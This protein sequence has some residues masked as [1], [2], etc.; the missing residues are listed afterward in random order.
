MRGVGQPVGEVPHPR[1]PLDRHEDGLH[2]AVEDVGALGLQGTPVE[3]GLE[4]DARQH[5][6]PL[7]KAHGLWHA[8]QQGLLVL[9][10]VRT[11][12][13]T[14]MPPNSTREDTLEV[15]PRVPARSAAG[16]TRLAV[17]ARL[18]RR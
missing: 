4:E 7:V 16:P 15:L 6:A 12:H 10:H 13:T 18:H 3:E 17:H 11:R 1:V 8:L 2:D 14:S 9:L 5:R